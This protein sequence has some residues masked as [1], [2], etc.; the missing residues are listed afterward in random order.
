MTLE[1]EILELRNDLLRII[2]KE[3]VEIETLKDPL[4]AGIKT[5][6]MGVNQ[7]WLEKVQQIIDEYDIEEEILTPKEIKAAIKEGGYL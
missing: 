4:Q 5:A 2:N 1:N 3:K 7:I 6:M